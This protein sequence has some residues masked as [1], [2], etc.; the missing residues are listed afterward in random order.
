MYAPFLQS[1]VDSQEASLK[2]LQGTKP[3]T[4]V[5]EADETYIEATLPTSLNGHP[6]EHKV[7][8]VRWNVS[9]DQLVFSLDAVLEATA[10]VEAPP[11]T[12]TAIDF[13]GPMYVGREKGEEGNKVWICLFTCCVTRDIHLE[14]VSDMSTVTFVRALKRFSARRGLP[15]KILS[16]NAKTFKAAVKLLKTIFD[17]QEVKDYLSNVGVES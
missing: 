7:L 4:D 8:G 10:T 13:A 1:L 9:L 6:T 16:D 15:R 5:V 12:Y 2:N 17:C 14:L 3:H 11:F